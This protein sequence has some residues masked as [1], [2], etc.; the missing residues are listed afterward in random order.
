MLGLV[1]WLLLPRLTQHAVRP[2]F[3]YNTSQSHSKNFGCKIWT[4]DRELHSQRQHCLSSPMKTN[5]ERDLRTV[6]LVQ[7]VDKNT[8]PDAIFRANFVP[9]FNFLFYNNHHDDST[10]PSI[11]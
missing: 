2:V 9:L 6:R 8:D 5:G 7:W 11:A 10:I 1:S 4:G 3:H